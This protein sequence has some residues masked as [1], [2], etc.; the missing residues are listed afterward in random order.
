MKQFLVILTLVI[1]LI[2]TP[3]L[4][5]ETDA[6]FAYLYDYNTG[7]VLFEK[8][9]DVQMG[10]SSMSKLMT[11][12][13]LFNAIKKGDYSLED[14]FPVSEKAWRKGGSKMFVKEGDNVAINDLIQGIA[15]QSGNDACIVVAEG[16][17]GSEEAFTDDMN[18][19]AEELGLKGSHFV[20]ATGW[21]DEGH[22]MTVH[23][24]VTLAVHLYE[25]FPDQYHVFSQP[26][27]KYADIKQHNRNK[28]LY[29]DIGAD[30][31]K[32][33]HT[34]ANG[35]G[36]T[37]SAEQDGR[38]LFVSV[39]GLDSSTARHEQAEK[40]LRHGFRDFKMQEVL[41]DGQKITEA[42]VWG[43]DKSKVELVTKDKLELLVP[44]RI[45]R[46]EEKPDVKVTYQSPLIA[47]LDP[48]K[49]VGKIEIYREGSL[50]RTI[51]L[52][53][54][55]KVEGAS[56]FSMKLQNLKKSLLGSEG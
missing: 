39:N 44:R 10:P 27:F 21:P 54:K 51:D 46:K 34:S 56:T 16:M 3:V 13:V 41:K 40:L 28:L 55:E 47:P 12:Y 2:S 9:A 26:S 38:R 4:A 23:D 18:A 35:Y 33:G 15:I 32:T 6:E 25:D 36:V 30:G 37:A 11:L 22:L 20:N 8:N 24:L 31:L 52:F 42:P 50:T 48:A 17:A 7:T 43:G 19:R 45:S 5:I 14:T 53:P 49:A 1:T 29:R